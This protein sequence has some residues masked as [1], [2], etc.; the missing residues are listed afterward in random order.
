MNS[1]LIA[2]LAVVVLIIL[3]LILKKSSP[4]KVPPADTLEEEI[5]AAPPADFTEAEKEQIS[6]EDEPVA[7]ID[8]P[9]VEEEREEALEAE[10]NLEP[11][12]ELTPVVIEEA[13]PEPAVESEPEIVSP[14]AAEPVTA[15]EEVG[16]GQGIPEEQPVTVIS[17]E[18]YEQRLIA[19]KEQRLAALSTA[20]DSNEESRRE[21]L[22]V[23]LVALTEALSF[24]QQSY[25]QEVSC[26]NSAL[27]TL[28]LMKPELDT[29]DYERASRS[30]REGDSEE[31]E[32]VFDEVADQDVA[33][34]ALAAY[35]SGCLAECR[36]DLNRAMERLDRAVT[37]DGS[38]PDYLRSAA[39]LARKLYL[40]KKALAWF[41]SLV[42]LLE[43]QGEDTIELALARREQA[44][45]SA[46]LGQHKQAGAL[47]KQAMVSL[48]SLVGK[49]D[50]E[51]G[52]CWYQIGKLQE[53]LGQYEKAEEPYR[54]ALAIMDKA[55]GNVV[56]GE[57]LDKLAGL[58]MELE[59]EPEAIPLFERLCAFKEE[60]PN[61]DNASLAMAYNNLA[62]AYRICG[63]YEESEKN[64]KQSLA[65][66]E[67][68]RGK[69]HAAVG[70]ILQE[71]AQLCERQRKKDEAKAYQERAAAIFQRVL[72]EQEAAGQE[73]VKLNLSD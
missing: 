57:I 27:A 45:T 58:Y 61:P 60:S 34:S 47:Y 68:L 42:Q 8:E 53:A 48:T 67:E 22:Q 65:I 63:K 5:S 10:V 33:L 28:E 39:L 43:K 23:E 69:D 19:L 11:E 13:P 32:Q 15:V 37:L 64:Y 59:R 3:V 31:A 62:E 29:A 46:L 52:I 56:L 72:E 17:L 26:R 18:S 66:T 12:A 16:A 21:Q 1:S 54:K 36:T 40:H 51:M 38:S 14:P 50:P 55:Q 20:I 30:V 49:D 70:S 2:V 7:E 6:E 44:Y 24:L 9:T 41:A 71:L 4:K 73:S 35:R 25:G